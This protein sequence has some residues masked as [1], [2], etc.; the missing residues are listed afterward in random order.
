VSSLRRSIGS[1][2]VDMIGRSSYRRLAVG[3]VTAAD[4]ERWAAPVRRL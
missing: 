2:A 4:D 3:R 1:L